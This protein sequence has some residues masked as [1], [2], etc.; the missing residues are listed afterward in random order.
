MGAFSPPFIS[1]HICPYSINILLPGHTVEQPNRIR[2]PF[3]IF[4]TDAISPLFIQ[5]NS[6]HA[7]FLATPCFIFTA[8]PHCLNNHLNMILWPMKVRLTKRR[9]CSYLSNWCCQIDLA[10]FFSVHKKGE[11][12][13]N[14][15]F[16]ALN[17]NFHFFSHSFN[18]M[19]SVLQ[20]FC[21]VSSP[22][23]FKDMLLLFCQP[24]R[25]KPL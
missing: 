6:M 4:H 23:G 2:K 12:L 17:Y 5:G 15:C 20:V 22:F 1:S 14:L 25:V 16:W 13:E 24:A 10:L 3:K 7:P 19:H 8:F 9:S 18:Q 21:C 11:M